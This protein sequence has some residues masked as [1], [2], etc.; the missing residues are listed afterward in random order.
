MRTVAFRGLVALWLGMAGTAAV[1]AD[2]PP[3]PP[4][5]SDTWTFN[6]TPYF[7]FA[8]LSGEVGVNQNLPVVE[9]D[10]NFDQIFE[11]I[12][13]WP[14]PVMLAGE[15]RYERFA[16]LTDFLFLGIEAG[17]ERALG[18]VAISVDLN[19]DTLIASLAGSYR[20]VEGDGFTFDL[21][22]GGRL[23]NLGANGAVIGPLAVRQR[24]GGKTWVDPIVGAAAA[25]DFGEG[26]SAKIQGDIGGFGVSAERDWQAIGALQYAVDDCVTLAAGYRHLAVDYRN[27]PFL[28][29]VE[30]SGPIIS[31]SFRLE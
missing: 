13:W 21:L 31:A 25:F 28:Y 10:I 1:H 30:F 9:V 3:P 18:P 16:V 12:D 29:D 15:A 6:L 27:G 22:A 2:E 23:W 24:S 7:W 14:P 19:M 8:S 20:V 11:H 4:M 17:A 26:F 5:A